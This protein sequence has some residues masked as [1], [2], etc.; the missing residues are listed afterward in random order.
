MKN[1]CGK[2]DGQITIYKINQHIYKCKHKWVTYTLIKA[3]SIIPGTF[4]LLI[5]KK[6]P[7]YLSDGNKKQGNIWGI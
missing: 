4:D 7:I 5:S 2:Y 6:H 3:F 1:E